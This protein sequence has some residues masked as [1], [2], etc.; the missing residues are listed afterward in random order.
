MVLTTQFTFAIDHDMH[1]LGSYLFF[2]FQ[3]ITIL[4]AAVLCHILLRHQTR[5]AIP[6]TEWQFR[7]S[8]HRF[9]VRFAMVVVGLAVLLSDV[10]PGLD[11]SV[12]VLLAVLVPLL[13]GGLALLAV[14]S[15]APAPRRRSY[16]R[17][18]TSTVPGSSRSPRRST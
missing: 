11:V 2:T 17:T 15:A 12:P 18:R 5:H 13:L 1:M 9:R 4:V 14:A 3:A 10:G 16:R 6:D 7:A 8:L